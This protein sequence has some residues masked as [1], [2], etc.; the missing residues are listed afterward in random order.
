MELVFKKVQT[1]P[2]NF[3]FHSLKLD[4]VTHMTN[5]QMTM[6]T[7]MHSKDLQYYQ[8]KILTICKVSAFVIE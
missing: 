2:T 1:C 3:L 7:V 6:V 5:M 8:I 4:H